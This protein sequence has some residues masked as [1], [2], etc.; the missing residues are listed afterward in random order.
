[1]IDKTINN[2]VCETVLEKV[3]NMTTVL[4]AAAKANAGANAT[5]ATY[6]EFAVTELERLVCQAEVNSQSLDTDV[7][8]YMA[9]IG[10]NAYKDRV[11]VTGGH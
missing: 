1:M 5:K 10:T 8:S 4:E 9:P 3:K 11:E 7:T 2:I 6:P